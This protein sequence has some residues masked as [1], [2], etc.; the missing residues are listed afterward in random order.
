MS[1][2]W[3]L[4]TALKSRTASGLGSCGFCTPG[5]NGIQFTN[6][7]E[8]YCGRV[9]TDR[10]LLVHRARHPSCEETTHPPECHPRCDRVRLV[11]TRCRWL[12][13]AKALLRRVGVRIADLCATLRPVACRC[14]GNFRTAY[15]PLV[16][17][18]GWR[19]LLGVGVIGHVE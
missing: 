8:T 2:S 11:E 17:G 5:Q 19:L 16:L 13:L 9:V 14:W 12:R 15:V 3:L 18:V 7:R 4:L 6:S 10:L 1:I